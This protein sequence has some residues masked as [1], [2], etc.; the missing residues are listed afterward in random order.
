MEELLE[1]L[2]QSKEKCFR[3]A[4]QCLVDDPNNPVEPT[5]WLQLGNLF[6]ENERDLQVS[7]RVGDL[8]QGQRQYSLAGGLSRRYDA[9]TM[10]ITEVAPL[11]VIDDGSVGQLITGLAPILNETLDEIANSEDEK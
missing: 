4:I 7:I 3:A 10:Q 11:G 9:D 1:D 5:T 8:S 2:K 6:K